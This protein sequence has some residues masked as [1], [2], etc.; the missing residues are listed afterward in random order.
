MLP[1]VLMVVGMPAITKG[2]VDTFATMGESGFLES[3]DAHDAMVKHKGSSR[4]EDT[5][6]SAGRPFLLILGI[7]DFQL[8]GSPGIE[9]TIQQFPKVK[10]EK[11]IGKTRFGRSEFHKR[12]LKDRKNWF[13]RHF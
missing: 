7:R 4:I 2:A 6:R 1:S 12:A 10:F 3:A 13:N 8:C 11:L 5:F 9:G